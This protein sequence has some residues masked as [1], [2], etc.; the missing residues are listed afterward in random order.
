MTKKTTEEPVK[1]LASIFAVLSLTL[2][3]FQANP[4][5]AAEEAEEAVTHQYIGVQ[6]CGMCHKKAKT[7]DQLKQWQES[8][9]AQAFATLATEKAQTIAT[10]RGIEDPQKAA[11]C[12]Q[13]HV[14]QPAA[15]EIATPRKGKE[16][17]LVEHGVQCETCHG[18]GS[19]YKSRKVM[20]D[21]DASIAA[22]LTI[23]DEQLCLTCHND[24]SP[25]F[26]GF[27]FDEM[28]A[29]VTHPNPARAAE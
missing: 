27:D 8:R 20:K 22:G 14:T 19:D 7:G 29:K 3:A 16:G 11:E 17:F 21:H 15:A 6:A 1:T 12:L 23:P 26:T 13:C 25:T 28:W 10:E 18:A 24:K 4:G 9:H 2:I 5:V